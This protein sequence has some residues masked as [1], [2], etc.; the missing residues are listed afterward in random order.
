MGDDDAAGAEADA[1][2]RAEAPGTPGLAVCKAHGLR[3]D[4]K[5]NV[6]CVLCRREP[7]TQRLVGRHTLPG[8][9][10]TALL[11][12]SIMVG[13]FYLS[14][15]SDSSELVTPAAMVS[16]S[17]SLHSACYSDCAESHRACS[18]QC[19]ERATGATCDDYCFAEA[20]RCFPACAARYGRADPPWSYYYGT[21]HMPEWSAVLNASV[22]LRARLLA[23]SEEPVVALAHVAVRAVDGSSSRVVLWSQ[24]IEEGVGACA[25]EALEKTRFPTSESG[26]YEF[27]ARFDSRY[28]DV[29]LVV[30]Q[31]EAEVEASS[32]RRSQSGA[33]ATKSLL[34]DAKV[35]LGQQQSASPPPE[36]AE[37]AAAKERL[38]AL[39]AQIAAMDRPAPKSGQPVARGTLFSYPAASAPTARPTHER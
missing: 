24:G 15:D 4:P 22:G 21:P 29:R 17:S 30:A 11:A 34:F 23:C 32:R 9:I 5:L 8:A 19:R 12:A 13:G 38:A 2:A 20:D 14:Q 6:G 31:A 10:V 33:E 7:R 27:L 28:D 35:V 36:A 26:D 1:D 18:G 37:L 25:R 16:G 3:Y 39:R